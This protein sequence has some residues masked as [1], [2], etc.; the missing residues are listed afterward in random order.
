MNISLAFLRTFFMILSIFF[1]TLFMITVP[2]GSNFVNAL[3]GIGLG[4]VFGLLLFGFDTVFRRFNLRS[5]N[6]AVIGLFFGYLMGQA[7]VLIFGAILDITAI[8]NISPQIIEVT[9][10]ALFLFGLY[11]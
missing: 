8:S 9:K 11:L 3:L 1:M 2:E 10:I 6:V 7:L 4:I 5:F